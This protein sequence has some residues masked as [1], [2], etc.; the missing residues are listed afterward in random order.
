[1][2][3]LIPALAIAFLC[4]MRTLVFAAPPELADAADVA[5]LSIDDLR[6]GGD[7]KKRYFVI[8]RPGDAPKEG[9]RALFV[10]PGGPGSADFLPFVARIAKFALPENYLVVQLVAPVWSEA[11]A[12]NVVWPSAKLRPA[13]AKFTT[14]DFFLAARGAVLKTHR[15]DPRY[16]FTLTWSSS[17]TNGY[18]LSLLPQAGVTGTFV[19]MSVFQPGQL[20]ALT[21]A[22]GH[23]Y[24][25]YHS[26]EDFIAFT[27]PE[28]AR[29]TLVKASATVELQTYEG[30]HGWRGDVMG[31]I[32]KGVKWLEEH[33]P[34]IAAGR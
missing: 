14:A 6:A 5:D 22:K 18:A 34:K 17:G 31:D 12:K 9:Y 23:P 33:A 11:Q 3:R 4:F 21:K 24:F 16:V 20:P 7:E 1:M 28:T 32:R 29:D 25:I 27:H 15:I 10:L 8:R 13:E 19:A 26:R 30:G 2:H